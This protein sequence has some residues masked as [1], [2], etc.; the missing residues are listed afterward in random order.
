MRE[1]KLEN[2]HLSLVDSPKKCKQYGC[3]TIKL[4][5]LFEHPKQYSIATQT[6]PMA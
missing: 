5:F 1:N 4:I 3:G 2:F 6:Q